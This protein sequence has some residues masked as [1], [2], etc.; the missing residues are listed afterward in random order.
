MRPVNRILAYILSAG[1]GRR[2]GGICKGRITL[3]GVPLIERQLDAMVEAGVDEIRVMVG[4][5]SAHIQEI[6]DEYC[7]RKSQMTSSCLVSCLPVPQAFSDHI[8]TFEMQDSV[9]HAICDAKST[10]SSHGENSGVLI[11]LV[12]LVLLNHIEITALLNFAKRS[13]ASVVIPC[14][15]DLQPGHPIW[16]ASRFLETLSPDKQ[17][18]S[19]RE[20]L[21]ADASATISPVLR[22]MTASLG[23]FFDIDTPEEL[24]AFNQ[25][26]DS[27]LALPTC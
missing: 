18:F 25:A 19:L 1:Y 23:Y 20:I 15:T 7:L 13:A 6:V 11:S 12:D 27:K 22:M 10:L 3:D 26:H 16:M 24:D 17:G 2:I 9:R 8:Q 5:E 21:H 4:H 14:S